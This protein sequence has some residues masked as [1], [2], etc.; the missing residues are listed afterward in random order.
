M[1]CLAQHLKN[2][3]FSEAMLGDF[4]ERAV[5]RLLKLLS[6]RRY[7]WESSLS[8]R[9][10][11]M[12]L[13]CDLIVHLDVGDSFD[14][15]VA[16]QNKERAEQLLAE[17]ISE[18]KAQEDWQGTGGDALHAAGSAIAGVHIPLHRLTMTFKKVSSTK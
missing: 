10:A 4:L 15:Q 17:M 2:N 5:E 9:K 7:V 16:K 3:N 12:N 13:G 18:K 1:Q 6:S 14:R 8:V 11:A